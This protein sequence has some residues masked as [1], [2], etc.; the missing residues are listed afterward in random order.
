MASKTGDDGTS[1][2]P[3]RAEIGGVATVLCMNWGAKYSP[4]YVNRLYAMVA[5]QL[6]QPVRFFLPHGQSRRHSCRRS[7]SPNSRPAAA[8]RSGVVQARRVLAEGRR[9]AWR[10]GALFDLDLVIVGALEPFFEQSGEFLIIRDWG[11]P[12]ARAGNASVFRFSPQRSTDLFDQYCRDAERITRKFRTE[13][14]YLT[15][16]MADFGALGFWPKGW[17]AELQARLHSGLAVAALADADGPR[18]RPHPCLSWGTQTTASV[19]RRDMRARAILRRTL[20]SRAL[21]G[22]MPSEPDVSHNAAL[23]I[24]EDGG[25]DETARTAAQM[26]VA[27]H[28]DVTGIP[29]PTLAFHS[30][31]YRSVEERLAGAVPY[32]IAAYAGAWVL[33]QWLTFS[34][35]RFDAYEML[36][37]GHEWQLAYWKHPALPPWMAEAV[38]ELSGRSTAAMAVLPVACAAVALWLVWRLCRP[39][40]GTTG[41]ALATGLSLCSWYLMT[42]VTQFNH[43]VAQLPFWVL[44]VLCYRRA[45]LKSSYANWIAFGVVAALLLQTKYTGVLLLATLAVHACWFET[46]RRR[47]RTPQAW[48]GIAVAI[49]LILP[50]LFQL[51]LHDRSAL[52]YAVDRPPYRSLYDHV[53]GPLAL[54]GLQ[55][56]FHVAVLIWCSQP[57]RTMPPSARGRWRSHCP[58]AR[59]STPRFSLR[60]WPVRSPSALS[61]MALR[62][63]G[64]ARRLWG[65]CSCWWVRP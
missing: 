14:E 34:G 7:V 29:F 39:I 55:A 47:L 60:V 63:C 62:E 45:I 48:T 18:G 59:H 20:D 11:R 46:S 5:R 24:G 32:V 58:N 6:W 26:A 17:C 53:L 16:Y 15:R 49:A 42:P 61:S 56:F 64:D 43:N 25:F 65:P 19:G 9:T 27:A 36:L 38:F 12:L 10:D 4:A 21:E 40:L 57:V 2:P 41:A 35:L 51:V 8:V 31:F 1:S 52:T 54:L 44:T 50:Q 30:L 37:M 28:V 23:P 3:E 22:V 33:V 13:G